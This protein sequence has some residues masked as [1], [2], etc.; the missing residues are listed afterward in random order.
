MCFLP[1]VQRNSEG[2]ICAVS[3]VVLPGFEESLAVGS[4]E[5]EDYLAQHR[6]PDALASTDLDFVRV[7]EDLLDVLIDKNI[8]L[9]TE[10]P[11]EAQ[12]KV[13]ARQLMRSKEN[14]LDLLIEE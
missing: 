4:T 12:Q 7:L 2:E 13:L 1:Y 14:A 11:P 6:S 10:L 5:L 9:F 3:D 8:L